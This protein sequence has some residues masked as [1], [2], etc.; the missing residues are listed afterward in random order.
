ME[1]WPSA[2]TQGFAEFAEFGS[3][4]ASSNVLAICMNAGYGVHILRNTRRNVFP[5]KSAAAWNDVVV[6]RNMG[7][8]DKS[9]CTHAAF[10]I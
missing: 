6:A 7:L 4:F 3:L 2:V 9:F 5:I 10:Y 1:F 8:A